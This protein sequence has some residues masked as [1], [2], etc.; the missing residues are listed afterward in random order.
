MR[1]IGGTCKC[2]GARGPRGFQGPRG[3]RG[4]RGPTGPSATCDYRACT[5]DTSCGGI[6]PCSPPTGDTLTVGPGQM[7]A[8][9]QAAVTAASSGDEI[10]VFPDTYA[11]Q[12]TIPVGKDNLLLVSQTPQAAII[13][14]PAGGVVG[15]FALVTT[16]AQC[17]RIS[18]FTVTGPSVV[19][20]NLRIGIYVTGGGSAIIDNNVITDIRDNPLSGLQ[21]GTGINVDVGSA[22]VVGN[23]ITSYQKTGI[24]IN[25]SGTCSAVLNNTVTGVGATPTIAQNGIQISRSATAFVQGNTVTANIYTGANFISTGILLFQ[26]V[27]TAPVCVQFNTLSNNDAGLALATTTESLVQGNTSSNNTQ[28]GIFVQSDSFNNVFI[29]NTAQDNPTFDIE[30]DSVGLLSALTANVYLCNTCTTD[31]KDGAICASTSP[32]PTSIPTT[33]EVLDLFAP[34]SIPAVPPVSE[35]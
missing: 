30:D 21:Q 9:I 23:T 8:T 10:L 19:Q 32:L 35:G 12:V 34:A 16:N 18:G 31:N 6:F 13:T 5:V 29:R 26:V 22:I 11:E 27:A 4:P 33:A 17:T 24:R 3:P 20:G 15:N 14:T 1:K 2:R 28:F 25:G 7:F